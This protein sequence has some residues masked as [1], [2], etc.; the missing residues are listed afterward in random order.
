MKWT[1]FSKHIYVPIASWHLL[2]TSSG[3]YMEFMCFGKIKVIIWSTKFYIYYIS[4]KINK[5][6]QENMNWLFIPAEQNFWPPISPNRKISRL[7]FST[8]PPLLSI[9]LRLVIDVVLNF[10]YTKPTS[11]LVLC[12]WSLAYNSKYL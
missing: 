4:C 1:I 6:K 12:S 5:I 8:T 7:L 9:S 11:S 2:A 3:K 10:T